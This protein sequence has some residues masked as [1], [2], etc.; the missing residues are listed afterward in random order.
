VLLSA[1]VIVPGLGFSRTVLLLAALNLACAIT[2]W[3]IESRTHGVASPVPQT[4]APALSDARLALT[5]L[6]TGLLGIGYE[7]LGVRVLAQVLENTIYSFAS[8]LAVYLL[9]TAAGAALGHRFLRHRISV[10]VLSRLLVGLSMSCIAGALALTQA[11]RV[12]RACRTAWGDSFLSVAAAEMTA[13]ALVFG[14]PTVLMGAVFSQLVQAAKRDRDGVGRAV[15]LNTLGAAAAPVLF[16][17]L[18]LPSCGSKGALVLVGLS[19]LCLVP[20][21]N[22]W[23]WIGVG[24]TIGLALLLPQTIQPPK[25]AR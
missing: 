23:L 3:L 5:V 6:I 1:F 10:T 17:V 21:I 22:R 13:A 11:D 4:S 9:G 2:V 25:L 24:A 7:V 14:F 19:Y 20:H 12:Y 16:G 15:A 8:A 18:L